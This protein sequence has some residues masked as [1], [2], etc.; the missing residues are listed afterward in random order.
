MYDAAEGKDRTTA[1]ADWWVA[2]TAGFTASEFIIWD[3]TDTSQLRPRYSRQVRG[4][5][6]GGLG[7]GKGHLSPSPAWWSGWLF[8]I[9][10]FLR[11]TFK[12]AK[13]FDAFCFLMGSTAL[14]DDWV[15][16]GV[17]ELPK[18]F[19]S[20]ES[21]SYGGSS[22]GKWG[23]QTLPISWWPSHCDK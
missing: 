14:A 22:W 1:E 10:I 7:S 23:I 3:V 17:G 12:S 9:F 19:L 18:T 15:Y 11:L 8:H 4:E 13:Q 21:K 5:T 20:V 2:A 16:S 6:R